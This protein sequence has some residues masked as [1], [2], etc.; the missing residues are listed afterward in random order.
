MVN[1]CAR[2]WGLIISTCRFVHFGPLPEHLKKRV[3]ASA[4]VTAHYI[5]ASKPETNA[6]DII[7]Q[8][9]GWFAEE[10]FEGELELHHQGGAIG[11]AERE[12][13]AFPGSREIIHGRQAFAWNPII[14]GA[15][16]FDTFVIYDD[17]VENISGTPDWPSIG[18]TVN[19]QK[20]RLPDILVR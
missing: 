15:L 10:G 17:R 5:S 16:S 14:Q 9:P 19:G 13:I 18:V 11:Y 1:V 7:A 20:V 4:N 3:R 6:G 12:W 8:A 2:K